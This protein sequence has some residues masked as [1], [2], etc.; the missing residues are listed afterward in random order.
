MINNR[1]YFL[2][3][4]PAVDQEPNE[5]F[6]LRL[7]NFQYTHNSVYKMF[8]DQVNRVPD[9]VDTVKNIPFLPISAFKY[10][11]VVSGQ[12][13]SQETFQSSGTTH[14]VLRS[15]HLIRDVALY[16]QNTLDIWSHHYGSLEDTTI[17]A[18]LPGYLERDGSSLI[19]MV[20]HFIEQSQ[21]DESGF[22]LRNFE[23]LYLRL[24]TNKKAHKKTVLIGVSYALLD[25]VDLYSMEFPELIIFETGGM[26]GQRAEMTKEALHQKIKVGFGVEKIHS[27]YGM[28]ELLSQ[29]YSQGDGIF[30]MNGRLRV[31]ISQINDPFTSEKM[32]KTGIVNVI[33]LCNIDSCAFIQTQDVGR[34]VDDQ[35]FEILGRLDVADMRGCN[36][37]VADLG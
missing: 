13:L 8:C 18:L 9:N 11:E 1:D 10:H 17:L 16:H 5:N 24:L 14:Q 27:E 21:H 4:M 36:L 29:S 3:N 35:S 34:L 28:T 26:K 23:E 37:L 7:F 25:F 32:G 22:Y 19:S 20:N 33:D 31:S 15:K 2:E 30:T 6:I 12:W